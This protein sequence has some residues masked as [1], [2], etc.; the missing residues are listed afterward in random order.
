ML[1]TVKKFIKDDYLVKQSF[2][3]AVNLTTFF[4]CT[5]VFIVPLFIQDQSIR[6]TLPWVFLVIWIT[7]YSLLR[8]KLLKKLND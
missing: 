4:G 3:L 2:P 7:Y 5:F 8:K 6:E 1:E